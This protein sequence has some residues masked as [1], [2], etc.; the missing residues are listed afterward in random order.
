MK[1]LLTL[2][3]L[4]SSFGKF[5]TSS[6]QCSTNILI[7]A[8]F[9]TPVQFAIGN[10]LLGVFTF[11]GWAIAGGPF[12][13]IKTDGSSYGGGPDNAKDGTQYVDI[14]NSAGTL[15]Q[16]F[17]IT[18]AN[19]NVSFGGYFSSREQSGGY[20]DWVAS[21]D[22]ID[23]G[24][25]TVVATSNTHNFTNADGADPAQETWHYVSG[26]GMLAAGNYRY[27]AN[28]GDFGNF[29]AAFLAQNC[30]LPISLKFFTGKITNGAVALNWQAES[31]VNFSHFTIE[32]STDGTSFY[33]LTKVL[34]TINGQYNFSDDNV[35]SLKIIY[36]RLKLVDK[37]GGFS[38][39]K[40]V[41]ILVKAGAA[42]NLSP[43]PATNFI[44]IDAAQPTGIISIFNAAGQLVLQKNAAA[45]QQQ[46]ID[47][48]KLDKGVY[49]LKYFNDAIMVSKKFIKQ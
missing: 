12:N 14:T 13:V 45:L 7:N 15:Y 22:I 31:A 5:Y 26:A 8:D 29:D 23:L 41:K 30:V 19:T 47:I 42:I 3:C 6:A 48:S 43:N 25:S 40:I 9:E 36:Y 10:N 39:S 35:K 24:T 27:V 38:Y 34:P 46:T 28:I 20:I 2:F 11:N 18:G 49:V 16:D 17:T 33:E 44:K 1:K 37:D 4:I 32:K 21:I